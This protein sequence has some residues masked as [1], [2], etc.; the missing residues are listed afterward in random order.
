LFRDKLLFP[1]VPDI[2]DALGFLVVPLNSSWPSSILIPEGVQ[3][4]ATAAALLGVGLLALAAVK[5]TSSAGSSGA[6]AAPPLFGL[7]ALAQSVLYLEFNDRYLVVLLPSALLV[8]LLAVGQVK[9]RSLVLGGIA[10][11][12]FWSVWWE[13]DYLAR[14]GAVWQA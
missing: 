2:L 8:S 4:V 6:L 3:I 13:R 5:A 9:R 12:A 7:L 1:F 11:T 10:L 14:Q